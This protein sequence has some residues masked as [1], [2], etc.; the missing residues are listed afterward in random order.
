[1]TSKNIKAGLVACGTEGVEVEGWV[2]TEMMV[3]R[4]LPK[5]MCTVLIL[6]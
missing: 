2:K 4:G 3:D 6:S 5:Y 1:M